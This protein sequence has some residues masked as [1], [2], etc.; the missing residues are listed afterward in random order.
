MNKEILERYSKALD[1]RYIISVT[2][3][4]ISDLYNNF[5]KQTP[6]SRKELDPDLA[7]YIIESA[8][9]LAKESFIIQFNLITSPDEAMIERITCSI[10]SYF[11]YLKT[12]EK[13]E[14]A[15]TMQTSVIFL[16]IGLAILFSSVWVNQQLSTAESVVSKVFAT[17]LTVAAWVS[18]WEALANFLVNWTPYSRQIKLFDQIANAPVEFIST[19]APVSSIHQSSKNSLNSPRMQ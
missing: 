15:R 19:P 4:K 1:G 17:G 12:I 11:L 3:D 2:A 10:N 13:R 7:E 14:L 9:D 18:L 16:A 5:D 6:Y 8:Q